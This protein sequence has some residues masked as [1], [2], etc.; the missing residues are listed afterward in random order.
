M[1]HRFILLTT[2]AFLSTAVLAGVAL[3]AETQRSGR[4]NILLIIADDMSWPHAGVYG[5]KVV[6]TPAIDRLARQGVLGRQ[7]QDCGND[8]ECKAE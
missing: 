5:D 1:K 4:P 2:V 6:K 8:L 3:C 7:Q